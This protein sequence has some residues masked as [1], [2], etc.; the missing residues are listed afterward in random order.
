MRYLLLLI[1]IVIL[2]TGCS[3]NT[4]N[5]AVHSKH[6][7]ND[8]IKIGYVENK[9]KTL[10]FTEG[11]KDKQY[12]F[13][14]FQKKNGKFNYSTKYEDGVTFDSEA[15]IP[16][17]IRTIN[18]ENVGNVIW[19][20]LKTDKKIAKVTIIYKN[21]K[22][23]NEQIEVD[24]PVKNNMFIGY[25]DKS[26]FENETTVYQD[27]EMSGTAYDEKGNVIAKY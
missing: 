6:K 8:T 20:A 13:S 1:S 3:Y 24:I 9:K 23:P 16:F 18:I 4:L 10:I 25:P 21:T 15:G 5:E 11:I 2:L 19:G 14:T 17:L 7:N 26:F 27:W 12:V 22:Y